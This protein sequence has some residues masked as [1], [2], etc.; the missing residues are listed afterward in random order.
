MGKTWPTVAVFFECG[1]CG[2]WHARDLPGNVD[3]RADAHRF[4]LDEL[5]EH[6]GAGRW[7]EITLDE[8]EADDGH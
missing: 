5:D 4:T 1:Q 3:C 8:Q 7:E 6:Y 2:H